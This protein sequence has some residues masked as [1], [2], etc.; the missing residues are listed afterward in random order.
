MNTQDYL[1]QIRAKFGISTDYAIAKK[2]GVSK[3]AAGRYSKGLG[4]FDDEVALRV[5]SL[6]G[7][8]PGLVLLDMH[9]E[10]AQ[11]DEAREIWEQVQ[12]GFHAPSQHA[13]SSKG[14]PLT[15]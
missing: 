12:K 10:R 8:H 9:K 15:R 14:Y 3:Q 5:A 11:T 13:K 7:I 6:T 1:A 2:L 4:G